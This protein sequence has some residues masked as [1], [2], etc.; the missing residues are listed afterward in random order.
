MDFEKAL[1]LHIKN[2]NVNSF[3]LFMISRMYVCMYLM[4]DNSGISLFVFRITI[5]VSVNC[6]GW[7]RCYDLGH[8]SFHFTSSFFVF[9]P[10]CLCTCIV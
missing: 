7:N 5:V 8:F 3:Y 10:S 9:I 2:N 4:N 1:L 6:H